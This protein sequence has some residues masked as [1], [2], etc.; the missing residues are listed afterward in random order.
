M[1]VLIAETS[2]ATLGLGNAEGGGEALPVGGC[3]HVGVEIGSSALLCACVWRRVLGD[4]VLPG[5][6]PK[7][8]VSY[9]VASDVSRGSFG[10]GEP[11][12][13]GPADAS[14]LRDLSHPHVP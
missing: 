12:R 7:A 6:G 3:S 10:I 1:G 13:A 4:F 11:Q 9:W 2:V 8:M 5:E 14:V